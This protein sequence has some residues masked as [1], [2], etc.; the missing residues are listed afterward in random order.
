MNLKQIAVAVIGISVAFVMF[1]DAQAQ[2]SAQSDGPQYTSDG[3]LVKPEN[4]REW[5]YLTSG[6]GMNYGA[7]AENPNAAPFFDNVFVNPSA[8]RAFLR[9]GTWPDKTV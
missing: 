3:L 6:L 1:R 8:Y 7:P 4:Y 5:V 2:N 9:T